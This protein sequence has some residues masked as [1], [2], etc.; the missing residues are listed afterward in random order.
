MSQGVGKAILAPLLGLVMTAAI[1]FLLPIP[2]TWATTILTVNSTT[3]ID[4]SASSTLTC[5]GKTTLEDLITCVISQTPVRNSDGF[6]V[7]TATTQSDWRDVIGQML[8]GNCSSITLTDTLAGVYS[9][10]KRTYEGKDYCVLMEVLDQISPSGIVDRGWGTFIVNM[11]PCRELSIQI[12]HPIHDIDTD[13]QGINV[14]KATNSRSFLMAGTHRY[15]NYVCSACQHPT[16]DPPGSTVSDPTT[17]KYVEADVAHNVA[18]LFQPAVEELLEYYGVEENFV[19]IQFHGMGDKYCS[20]VDVYLT[21]GLDTPPNT[22]DKIMVLSSNLVTYNSGWTVTVPGDSPTCTLS[23]SYNVQGRLLNNVATGDVCITAAMN[24]S[25]RF[26]HIEQKKERDGI[27][28]R[29]ADNW[30][31]A[32]NDTFINRCIIYLPIILKKG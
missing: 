3:S 26:I 25:G 2:D 31:N 29:D 5:P 8:D 28:F 22:G 16:C 21:H 18:N 13:I 27:S 17:E 10:S 30:I 7:P 32:I 15:A 12:A 19:A 23:G 14:F 24:Y 20:G 11:Q 4:I 9:V 1:L 6:V